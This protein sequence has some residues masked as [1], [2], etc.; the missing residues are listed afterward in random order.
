[1]HFKNIHLIVNPAAGQEE[2]ILSYINKAFQNENVNWEI[3]VTKTEQDAAS[4]AQA[5]IG[6]TDLIAVYGGD[7]TVSQVAK[8]LCGKPTPLAII[9]GGTANVIAKELAIPQNTLQALE[10]LTTEEVKVVSIDMGE[11]N[12][13]PFIIRVNFGIMA[14]MVLEADRELKDKVGQFAYGIT[15]LQ[16]MIKSTPISYKMVIDGEKVTEE[17]VALTVTNCGSI[18]IGNYSFLPQI[19]NQ[20]GFLDVLLLKQAN[21]L[22]VL[23]LT[24]TTLMQTDSQVLQHWRCKQVQ[25]SLDNPQTIIVDDAPAESQVFTI[26]IVPN[27]LN[28]VIPSSQSS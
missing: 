27:A 3:L 26:K 24:G 16:T 18:G 13:E 22:S 9:P 11:L 20:D 5:L 15:A 12:G 7:G 23:R 4:M 19:S 6:K 25:I 17:G 21:L 2:P 1:M 8:I 28:I 10:L 14:D